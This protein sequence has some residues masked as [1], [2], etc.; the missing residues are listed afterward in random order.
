MLQDPISDV[1]WTGARFVATNGSSFLTSDDGLTWQRQESTGTLGGMTVIASGPS[2]LVAIGPAGRNWT[3]WWSADGLTW[4]AARNAFPYRPGRGNVFAV[5]DVVAT[6]DGWLAVGREDPSCMFTC[7]S[8]PVRALV[9]RSTDGL[10]WTRRAANQKA[11]KGGAMNA[12]VRLGSGFLAVGAI[13]ARAGI[14]RSPDGSSWTRIA[15]DRTFHPKLSKAPKWLS[16][17]A[18]DVAV[19]AMGI[20][21]V[22]D[23]LGCQ[24][25]PSYCGAR[26]WWSADGRSWSEARVQLRKDNQIWRVTNTP[27][28]FLATGSGGGPPD[29]TACVGGIWESADARTWSCA[30]SGP[31]FD[32]FGMSAPAASPARAVVLGYLGPGWDGDEDEEYRGGG[33]W[34]PTG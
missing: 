17:E 34:R 28:G 30:A 26:A 7:A 5:T 3:S 18:V 32:G 2:G 24:D 6:G 13:G 16:T 12:V 9:W 23:D 11:L 4:R 8:E 27:Y 31:A 29:G 10:H 22:G 20:A 33:W 21:V 1:V 19:G 15:D 14:W 25:W